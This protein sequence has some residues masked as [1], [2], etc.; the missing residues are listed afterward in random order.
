M[1]ISNLLKIN[2]IVYLTLAGIWGT[3]AS[4][5]FN[6]YSEMKKKYPENPIIQDYNKETNRNSGISHLGFAGLS[7]GVSGVCFYK[8]RKEKKEE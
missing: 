6:N 4:L 8:S 3:Y 5:D 2:G 1:K 7:A